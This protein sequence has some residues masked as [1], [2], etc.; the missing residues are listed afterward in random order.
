MVEVTQYT[1]SWAEIAEMLI[2]RQGIHEAASGPRQWSSPLTLARWDRRLTK[3]SL[4]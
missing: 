3:Q 1:F 2:K 4:A